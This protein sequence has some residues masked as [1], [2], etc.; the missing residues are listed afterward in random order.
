ML[1]SCAQVLEVNAEFV[2]LPGIIVVSFGDQETHT[3]ECHF[4]KAIGGL[5]LG[6][7]QRTHQIYRRV[8]H[9]E[10]GAEEGSA[11]LTTLMSEPPLWGK[12]ATC[13]FAFGCGASICAV[14]FGGSLLDMA[15]GGTSSCC[16]TLLRLTFAGKNPV[17]E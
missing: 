16:L 14:A 5:D 9:D 11:L 13:F 2:N 15:A 17:M 8:V 1:S 10:I 4:V 6:R 12:S 3:S 7:V